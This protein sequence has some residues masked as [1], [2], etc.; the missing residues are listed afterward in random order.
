MDNPIVEDFTHKGL[1]ATLAH[2]LSPEGLRTIKK[3]DENK[4][5]YYQGII[6]DALDWC[7]NNGKEDLFL[8]L[9]PHVNWEEEHYLLSSACEGGSAVIVKTI[10]SMMD[11][12][13]HGSN[14]EYAYKTA[15]ENVIRSRRPD[16]ITLI[17]EHWENPEFDE[18][19]YEYSGLYAA[20]AAGF[21]EVYQIIYPSL[22]QNERRRSV[23]TMCEMGHTHLL[24]WVAEQGLHLQQS[25]WNDIYL[26]T[27]RASRPESLD[28]LHNN[29]KDYTLP[30][31]E[32]LVKAVSFNR[33]EMIEVLYKKTDVLEAAKVL[34]EEY[35]YKNTD[36]IMEYLVSLKSRD[37][38]LELESATPAP[39]RRSSLSRL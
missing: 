11:Q 26:S 28:W 34:K 33:K 35:Q 19:D 36:A 20:S 31:Q 1:A 10:L 39:R 32:A 8:A 3:L 25:D 7:A 38:K 27:V 30:Y 18:H 13:E 24:D 4:E 17:L 15:M 2:W 14:R 29:L 37:A 23:I 16:L 21:L 22:S 9:S 5:E 12:E 6:F